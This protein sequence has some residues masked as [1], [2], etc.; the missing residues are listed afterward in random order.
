[1][2]IARKSIFV[3]GAGSGIGRAAAVALARKGAR[4]TLSGRREEPL[5]SGATHRDDRAPVLPQMFAGGERAE[6]D[7]P[8]IDIEQSAVLRRRG[9]I[10]PL[11]AASG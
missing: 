2:H 8:E 9:R 11:C 1:M 3:T 4:L 7:T 10:L 6:N 5:R